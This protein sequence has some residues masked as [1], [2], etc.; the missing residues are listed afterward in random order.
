MEVIKMKNK[1]LLLTITIVFLTLSITPVYAS[2]DNEEPY[3]YLYKGGNS[4]ARVR[5]YIRKN[6][7]MLIK[8]KLV[9]VYPAKTTKTDNYTRIQTAAYS[10]NNSHVVFLSRTLYEGTGYSSPSKIFYLPAVGKKVDFR[11]Y[12]NNPDLDAYC[13]VLTN[14]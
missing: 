10:D 13:H 14:V 5:P 9:A 4:T 1:L 2:A 12:G 8:Q 11:F 7:T 3:L 6:T